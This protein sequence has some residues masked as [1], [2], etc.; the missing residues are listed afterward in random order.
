MLLQ[1]YHFLDIAAKFLDPEEDNGIDEDID[2]IDVEVEGPNQPSDIELEEALDKLYNLSF[3]SLGYG[4][5][6]QSPCL[7]I[8]DLL[9]K[10]KLDELRKCHV[11]DLF[12]SCNCYEIVKFFLIIILLIARGIPLVK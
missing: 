6:I 1:R 2:D 3:F 11:T 8:D 12:R 4:R 5:E 7:E 10:E 9:H